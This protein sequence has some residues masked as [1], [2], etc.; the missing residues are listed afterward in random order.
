MQSKVKL[1]EIVKCHSEAMPAIEKTMLDVAWDEEDEKLLQSIA[2]KY[3]QWGREKFVMVEHDVP[4]GLGDSV[5]LIRFG[6]SLFQLNEQNPDFKFEHFERLLIQVNHSIFKE[7][8][9]E[10]FEEEDTGFM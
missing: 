8:K 7:I 1:S 4:I 2:D 3:N 6:L 9:K 10:I 5:A